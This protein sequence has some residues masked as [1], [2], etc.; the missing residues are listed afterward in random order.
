M[1][2]GRN[3]DF[4]P[5]IAR[6]FDG[7]FSLQRLVIR[8]ESLEI[9]RHLVLRTVKIVRWICINIITLAGD[10]HVACAGD[11]PAR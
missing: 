2:V 8:I 10:A 6:D 9:H 11:F 5:I 1:A 7:S 4:I 3:P